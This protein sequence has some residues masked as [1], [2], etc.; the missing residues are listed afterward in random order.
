MPT[1]PLILNAETVTVAVGAIQEHPRNPNRSELSRIAES[2]EA[3]GFYGTIIVQRSTGYIVVGNHRYRAA[4]AAGFEEVPVTYIDVDEEKAI[5]ILVKDNRL[6][7]FGSRDK[8]VLAELLRE[9]EAG[10]GFGGTGFT[11]EE[12]ADLFAEL[13]GGGGGGGGDEG[14]GDDPNYVRTVE[15]PIYEPKSETPP[16]VEALYDETKTRELLGRIEEADLPEGVRL[17]LRAAASRHTVF[18]Y[19]EIAEFYAHAN[20]ETQALF[21][22]SALV[23]IDFDAAVEKGFVRL[24]GELGAAYDRDEEERNAEGGEE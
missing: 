6:A 10:M 4:V 24:V 17:F 18:D 20:A 7:E 23:I 2:I 5:R 8:E 22:D 11:V 19:E 1:E 16:P 12:A 21:E 15:A 14:D 9:I 13:E 3:D